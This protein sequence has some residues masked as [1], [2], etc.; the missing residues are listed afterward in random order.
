MWYCDCSFHGIRCLVKCHSKSPI[1]SFP[2]WLINSCPWPFQRIGTTLSWKS[3][4]RNYVSKQ[5]DYWSLDWRREALANC[6]D[7]GH[8]GEGQRNMS[9][10]MRKDVR[11]QMKWKDCTCVWTWFNGW[12]I[13][14]F[15][16]ILWYHKRCW[17]NYMSTYLFIMKFRLLGV[18]L[19][20]KT[21]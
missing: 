5:I 10:L 7:S 15:K 3:R 21:F 13:L 8:P 12:Q 9:K 16:L 19:D 11:W 1:S 14:I 18:K 6:S 4:L 2:S 20:T 17:T